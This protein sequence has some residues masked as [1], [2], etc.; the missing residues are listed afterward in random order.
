MAKRT[1]SYFNPDINDIEEVSTRYHG[2][3][4]AIAGY[5]GVSRECIYQY[6]HRTPAG[7]AIIDKTRKINNETFMD[8]AEYV[9]RYN[10]TN[11]KNDSSLA[12]RAAEKVID[13]KGRSRG[14]DD[15]VQAETQSDESVTDIQNKLMETQAL[16]S[17]YIERH[18]IINDISNQPQTES[19]LPGSD[20]PL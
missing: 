3:I 11:Y 18:G 10:L 16:L 8:L 17:K 15:G 20:T 1:T 6:M 9:V 14:W 7:K 13:K 12:Q 2:N 4:A 5:Y 19:E